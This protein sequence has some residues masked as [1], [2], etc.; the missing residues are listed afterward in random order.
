MMTALHL[1]AIILLCAERW[2]EEVAE[3]KMMIQKAMKAVQR[4]VY[5]TLTMV[6]VRLLTNRNF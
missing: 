1:W 2:I 5:D 6:T 4:P 3:R